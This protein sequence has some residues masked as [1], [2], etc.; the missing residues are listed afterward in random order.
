MD[1]PQAQTSEVTREPNQKKSI[2]LW[3]FPESG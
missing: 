1:I 2:F 3:F